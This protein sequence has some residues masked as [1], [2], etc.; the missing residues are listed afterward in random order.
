MRKSSFYYI[1]GIV[2][3]VLLASLC[4]VSWIL[5]AEDSLKYG[6]PRSYGAV[7]TV[8]VAVADGVLSIVTGFVLI[9][10]CIFE[11]SSFVFYG[12][13]KVMTRKWSML[14]GVLCICGGTVI[15]IGAASGAYL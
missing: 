2:I 5:D 4:S 3:I 9:F 1:S 7:R 12:I 14:A 11:N 15:L 13:R 10:S 6:S 8:R